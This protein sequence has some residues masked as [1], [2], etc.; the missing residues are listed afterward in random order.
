MRTQ[1]ILSGPCCSRGAVYYSREG[2]RQADSVPV[3]LFLH[4]FI[5]FL[6]R[7]LKREEDTAPGTRGYLGLRN[8]AESAVPLHSSRCCWHL[9]VQE[10]GGLRSVPLRPVMWGGA[11]VGN[12]SPAS[13][14]TLLFQILVVSPGIKLLKRCPLFCLT[15]SH[16]VFLQTRGKELWQLSFTA[17]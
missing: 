6:Q 14:W 9:G 17:C 16:S 5:P 3:Q 7:F 15:W 4:I 11:S 12:S 10:G 13:L 8:R 1:K 2:Q